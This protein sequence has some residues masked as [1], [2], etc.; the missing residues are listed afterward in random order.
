MS[1]DR[2][3]PA[4]RV[5]SLAI[6]GNVAWNSPKTRSAST[7]GFAT[8]FDQRS[9]MCAFLQC[10]LKLDRVVSG[11]CSALRVQLAIH[12][13]HAYVRELPRVFSSYYTRTSKE[14][15]ISGKK[16]KDARTSFEFSC[17]HESITQYN[18]WQS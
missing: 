13:V 7:R 1:W 11:P 12:S 5:V 4:R 8:M 14:A 16:S 3:V 15:L 10:I 9:L 6:A 17:H 2:D 18:N